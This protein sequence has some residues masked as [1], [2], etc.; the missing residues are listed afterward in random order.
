MIR[1]GKHVTQAGDQ[2]QDVSLAKFHKALLNSEG[3][4]AILQRRLQAIRGIDPAQYRKQKTALPYVVCA[5]FHPKVR[6]KENFIQTERFILDLD[7]LS[8]SGIELDEMRAQFQ[9]D[10]RVE[11]LYASPSGDGLKVFF[12]LDQPIND[13]AYYAAFYK[14]FG[15][16]LQ[17][18][19]QLQEVLDIKTHDVSRCC[20]VSF[21][22]KAYYNPEAE[23]VIASDYL[24]KEDLF[25]LDEL[26]SAIKE[27]ESIRKESPSALTDSAV[28]ALPDDA[29]MR[30]REKMGMKT[31]APR[32][33]DYVQPEELEDIVTQMKEVLLEVELAMVQVD[34]ISY[35]RKCRIASRNVNVWAEINVF[36]GRKGLSFVATTK[37]GSDKALAKEVV[38]YLD[39]TINPLFAHG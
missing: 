27:A 15:L 9:Q 5:D 35:G 2:L 13:S 29:I 7:H 23:P 4:V 37:T 25:A 33:K 20:F 21:D 30:I 12:R 32:V 24:K 18:V 39:S 36:L 28:K 3:E 1:L 38:V 19:Y 31:R 17:A 14:S 34:P 8:E 22:P 16:K 6:R 26:R 11:L 10:S